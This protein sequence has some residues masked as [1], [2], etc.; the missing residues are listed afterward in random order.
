MANQ[1][2][3]LHYKSPPDFDGNQEKF[4]Q[5]I[6]QCGLYL[7]G[8]HQLYDDNTKKITFILSCMNTGEAN[9]WMQD[10]LQHYYNTDDNTPV[11]RHNKG[12]VETYNQFTARLQTAFSPADEPAFTRQA[13]RMMKQGNLPIEEFNANFR[14]TTAKARVNDDTQLIEYYKHAID[15]DIAF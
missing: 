13:L 5:W 15:K 7:L 2:T 3:E 9:Y 12:Y 6:A 4:D 14:I 1:P 10:Y 8:N 11:D